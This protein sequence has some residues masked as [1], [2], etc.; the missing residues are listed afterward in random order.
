MVRRNEHVS[1]SRLLHSVKEA[2][3]RL[4]CRLQI[5]AKMDLKEVEKDGGSN[6]LGPVQEQWWIILKEEDLLTDSNYR[7]VRGT[8]FRS[9]K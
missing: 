4:G 7:L 2:L 5:N 8:L 6:S 9:V 3:G 1:D